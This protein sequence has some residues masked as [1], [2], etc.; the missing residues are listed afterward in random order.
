M[1]VYERIFSHNHIK[2]NSLSLSLYSDGQERAASTPEPLRLRKM[3]VVIRRRE[4]WL[5]P[6]RPSSERPTSRG[7]REEEK[8]DGARPPSGSHCRRGRWRRGR[9][10]AP[11][12]RQDGGGGGG[13]QGGPAGGR[14]QVPGAARGGGLGVREPRSTRSSGRRWWEAGLGVGKTEPASRAPPR[15]RRVARGAD[16]ARLAPGRPALGPQRPRPRVTAGSAGS[17]PVGDSLET[18]PPALRL[19][20]GPCFSS[21]P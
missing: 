21:S 10:R 8:E 3:G 9:T 5:Q 20:T 18:L 1:C 4:A 19:R 6:R 2:Y 11:R 16:L 14:Q 12:R 15:T 13:G 17:R 7:G